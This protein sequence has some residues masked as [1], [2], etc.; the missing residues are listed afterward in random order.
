[1]LIFLILQILFKF[2]LNLPQMLFYMCSVTF[3]YILLLRL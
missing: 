1:M 3:Y 2:G